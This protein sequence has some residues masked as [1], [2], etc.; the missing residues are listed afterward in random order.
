MLPVQGVL[1]PQG[2]LDLASLLLAI[3]IKAVGIFLAVYL[4]GAL[5]TTGL[6]NILVGA[7]AGVFKNILDIYFFALIISIILSWVAPQANHP[8]ALLVYQLTEPLMEPVR[9]FIPSL[10]GLDLS[11]IFVFL[12]INLVSSLVLSFL[13]PLAGLPVARFIG[14]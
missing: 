14:F 1:R 9:R 4:L 10:G 13:A 8:G 3:V 6:G 11:P 7:V 5:S 12:G 2:R